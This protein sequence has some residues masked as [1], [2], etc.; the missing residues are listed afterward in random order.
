[1]HN[2]YG[3]LVDS[4]DKDYTY[5]FEIIYPENRIVLDYGDREDIILLGKIHT[6]TGKD[7]SSENMEQ[8][9]F[10]TRR[11]FKNA[12]SNLADLKLVNETN[13]EGFV[14]HWPKSNVRVKVK[15]EEY[16]RLHKIMTGLSEKGIWEMLRENQDLSL[17]LKNVPDEFFNWFN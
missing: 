4:L 16:K 12:S 9:L 10:P 7:V 14:V 15:M 17:Y 2:K 13:I 8:D 5:I 11:V 6:E 1:L 3:H